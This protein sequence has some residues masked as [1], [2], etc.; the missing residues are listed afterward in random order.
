MTIR[1]FSFVDTDD[2]CTFL[3]LGF[4]SFNLFVARCVSISHTVG[5]AGN[6]VAAVVQTV[7]GQRYRSICC[8]VGNRQSI[9]AQY[10]VARGD[11]RCVQ[12][13]CSQYAVADCHFIER[14]IV[15][16]FNCQVFA[17]AFHTDILTLFHGHGVARCDFFAF[18]V[19]FF[20]RFQLP[21]FLGSLF[22]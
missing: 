22:Y 20:V 6:F 18:A 7:F 10:A 13:V 11:L 3:N 2:V 4:R 9:V 1:A 19:G 14:H 15:R 16:S 17:A 12:S 5:N 21:T 8:T